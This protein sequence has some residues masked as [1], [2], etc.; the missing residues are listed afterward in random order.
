MALAVHTVAIFLSAALLFSVQP[1]FARMVLPSLGGAPAVWNSCLFFF[2]G[3]L[4]A[5]YLYVH[6]T[7]RFLTAR[8]QLILHGAV[9]F[10]PLLCLPIVLRQPLEGGDP[11]L[12]L[13]VILGVSLGGPVFAV[14]TTTPLLQKW[15]SAGNHPLAEDPYFLYSASNLGS[16][17]ALLSYPILLE[18]N[19]SLAQQSLMWS[20]GYGAVGVLTLACGVMLWRQEPQPLS[21]APTAEDDLSPEEPGRS[22]WLWVV[23]SF[24][25]ASWLLAVTTKV[26]GDLVPIPMLWVV[27]L[28]IYLLTYIL[29]FS[30]WQPLSHVWMVRSF[31]VAVLLL[32]FLRSDSV[33]QDM[34]KH[35]AVFF[36]GAMVFHGELAR[37]RPGTSRLTE[38]YV[39]MAVGGLL[40]GMFNSLVGPLLF[41]SFWEY[42]LTLVLACLLFWR[43]RSEHDP[44]DRN[45]WVFLPEGL[46]V[47]VVLLVSIARGSLVD[48]LVTAVPLVVLGFLAKRLTL[49]FALA[50]GAVLLATEFA[51]MFQDQKSV[52]HAERTFFGVHRVLRD[53]DTGFHELHH[54]RTMHG[55]QCVE[56]SRRRE[57]LAYFHRSGPLGQV[58]GEF[59]GEN[60]KSRIAVVGLGTGTIVAYRE[61]GQHFTFYEIDPAIQRIAESPDLFTY[62]SDSGNDAYDIVLGDGRVMLARAQD[63]SFGMIILDAFSSDVIPVHLLT[64][65][66]LAL[67]YRKLADDGFLVIHISNP[68]VSLGTVLGNLAADA[69][70]RCWICRDQFVPTDQRETGREP[71][72][73]A[74]IARDESHLGGLLGS[75]S[76]LPW[77]EITP[78]E[79]GPAWTDDFSDVFNILR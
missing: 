13:L 1:L 43:F 25:P 14:C 63:R 2:Q 62:L 11:V 51:D 65:E 60:A 33:L 32:L 73:Y 8:R 78:D 10:L 40:G 28:S 37:R 38:F 30:R 35:L 24:V 20:C 66:A 31:P 71:T 29:A 76:D 22:R 48:G 27:P 21:V 18:P 16:M 17:V 23:F 3:V 70:S 55:M 19:L 15:F 75:G 69:G 45:W 56:P 64:R 9:L 47:A 39:W 36:V 57:P 26:T 52:L 72:L 4:L 54:G 77:I 49:V 53:A 58:F 74:V 5:G 79:P 50:V 59:S 67:Y 42:P 6:V 61:P 7:S 41:P 12:R 34:V 68:H 46:A 44:K